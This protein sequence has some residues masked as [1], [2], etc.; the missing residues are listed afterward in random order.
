MNKQFPDKL[1]TV[2]IVTKWVMH[3]YEPILYVF[4]HEEDGMWEFTGKT[5][6][7]EDE[8]YNIIGLGEA[9][10]LEPDL[11][12]IAD[13]PPGYRAIRRTARGPWQI[14]RLPGEDMHQR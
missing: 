2:V 8:D 7:I 5:Q 6:G 14:S 10:S 12:D 4:H 13:L 3:K 11:L 9:I 1:T